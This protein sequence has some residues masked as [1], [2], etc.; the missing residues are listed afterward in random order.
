MSDTITIIG[1][2]ATQ[3]ELK[4]TAGGVAI[5]TFRV[6]SGQRRFDRATGAWIDNGTNWYSVSAFRGLGENTHRSIHKGDR[7]VVTGRLRLR[8]WDTGVKSGTTAEIDAEAIGHDLLWGTTVFHKSNRTGAAAP[9]DPQATWEPDDAG[10][11]EE[12]GDDTQPATMAV[13]DWGAPV[14]APDDARALTAEAVEA[15]F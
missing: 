4:H 10:A 5:T 2:V 11:A 9:V 1:N 8:S 6:A 12:S 14:S 3:P 7:V 13:G 15:P